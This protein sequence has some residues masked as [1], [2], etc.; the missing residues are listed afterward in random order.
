MT[1]RLLLIDDMAMIRQTIRDI[2]SPP[3]S[4]LVQLTMLIERGSIPVPKYRIDEA[5]QGD[6]GVGMVKTAVIQNDP[7]SLVIV[8]MQMPPGIDGAETIRRIREVDT[9][10]PVIIC[11]GHTDSDINQILDRNGAPPPVIYKPFDAD[12]LRSIV[13]EKAR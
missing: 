10:I 3:A 5:D 7:Y 6:T 13:Q 1:Q 2:L 11:T 4:A 12:H 8:D 9:D